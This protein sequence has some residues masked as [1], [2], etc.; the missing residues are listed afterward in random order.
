MKIKVKG[1]WI[2]WFYLRIKAGLRSGLSVHRCHHRR[3][4]GTTESAD[5]MTVA[6]PYRKTSSIT[7]TLAF[8]LRR[9]CV[10]SR[11][12]SEAPLSAAFGGRKEQ[13]FE[14]PQSPFC[15]NQITS[16]SVRRN[17]RPMS[18]PVRETVPHAAH[19]PCRVAS[20]EQGSAMGRNSRFHRGVPRTATFGASCSLPRV[21][22]KVGLPKRERLLSVVGGN[23]SSCPT[24]DFRKLCRY[25]NQD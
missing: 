6:T 23:A 12:A 19:Q 13:G 9:W 1:R 14:R 5:K 16:P 11:T 21:P 24:A 15:A 18:R 7:C 22:A 17:D 20:D 4:P 10:S 2:S 3:A 25:R 8:R